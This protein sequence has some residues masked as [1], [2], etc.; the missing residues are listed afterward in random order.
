MYFMIKFHRSSGFQ[1]AAPGQ[2]Y[3]HFADDFHM[4]FRENN[5]LYFDK[6]INE[7]CS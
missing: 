2:Q 6:K 4:H 7:V 3:R 1:V 5:V